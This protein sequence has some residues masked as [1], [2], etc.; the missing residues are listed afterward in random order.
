MQDTDVAFST[1]QNSTGAFLNSKK[2]NIFQR[3][4]NLKCYSPQG[5][6]KDEFIIKLE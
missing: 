4:F 2:I 5:K 3:S 6:N 1:V